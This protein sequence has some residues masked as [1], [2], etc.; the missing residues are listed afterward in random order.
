[1]P[2]GDLADDP[3]RR[4]RAIGFCR[5]PRISLVCQ[6]GI[7][8]ERPGRFDDVDSPAAFAARQLRSPDARVQRGAEVHVRGYAIQFAEVGGMAGLDQ[9]A[10]F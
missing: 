2:A 7:V 5:I 9:V 3:Q 4:A 10:G 6:V 1:M 8:C